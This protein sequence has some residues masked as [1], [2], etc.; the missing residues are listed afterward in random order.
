M[1]ISD[2]VLNA[3][4]KI[5][6][7]KTKKYESMDYK[8]IVIESSKDNKCKVKYNGQ[9][10]SIENCTGRTFKTGDT[11]WVH[12]P[13]G[14]DTNQYIIASACGK[15]SGGGGGTS[16]V[17]SVDG[18]IGDV[19]LSQNYAAKSSEHFHENKTILDNI[20]NELITSWNNA[21][22]HISDT[23]KHIT[24]EERENWN[25]AYN[26]SQ[27]KHADPKAQENIIESI[28]VNDEIIVPQNKEINILVPTK[29]SELE[30]NEKYVKENTTY[31]LNEDDECFKLTGSDESS[32]SVKKYK[33]PSYQNYKSGLY[34]IAVDDT[35]HVEDAVLATSEDFTNMGLLTSDTILDAT[36]P[37]GSVYMS[38]V[39]TEPS[40]LFGGSW[41]RI[42]D[43]FLLA[44]G[45]TYQPN[46]NG[47]SAATTLSVE[48][49]PKHSHTFTGKQANTGNASANHT[50]S[51]PALSGSTNTTGAHTHK[52]TS[53]SS[54]GGTGY[55]IGSNAG[56]HG[57]AT[58][59]HSTTS[60]GNH[61]HTVSTTASTTGNM[62]ANHTHSYT[63]S[64]TIGE[65]GSGK[66][67][68]NLPPY[69]TIYAWKRIG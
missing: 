48:N 7:N 16:A 68:N 44:S 45:D 49:I 35:G 5:V 6:L 21:V 11:V 62:S 56:Y 30:N 28:S 10:Y 50:H 51:I 66:A 9:I 25:T 65:T 57:D 41:E 13:N 63:P 59:N 18:K 58:T 39:S 52:E 3:I 15:V 55:G 43:V 31:V 38:F 26:H 22:N 19:I 20:S 32:S 54:G 8:A 47:G 46:S 64:G 40:I 36:H 33:H 17:T 53:A 29:V 27:S 67:F 37:I 1:G 4:E 14:S 69:L 12:K 34:K 60:A 2:T 24:G 23:I 61:S 42:K